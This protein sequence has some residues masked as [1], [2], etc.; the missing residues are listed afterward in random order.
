MATNLERGLRTYLLTLSGVTTLVSTRIYGLRLPQSPTYPAVR[1]QEVG[2]R[3]DY[4]HDGDS[5]L[6]WVRMQIDSVAREVSG[7]DPFETV[8]TLARAIKG[9]GT[10]PGL[11]GFRGTWGTVPNTVT[12]SGVFL[13]S[14]FDTYEPDELQVVRR[15]Q[16]YRI[17]F[18]D[19]D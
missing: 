8:K 10:T 13:I 15:L 1:F 17:Q 4:T 7:T 2:K 6:S 9:S 16:E 12:V 3:Q 11:S 5:G 18:R 19:E 14:E